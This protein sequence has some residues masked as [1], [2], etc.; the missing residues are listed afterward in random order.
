MLA[1]F[2]LFL[3]LAFTAV[4]PEAYGADAPPKVLG[5]PLSEVRS[6]GA[7]PADLATILGRGKVGIGGIADRNEECSCTDVLDPKFPM[8]RLVLGGSNSTRVVVAIERGGGRALRIEAVNYVRLNDDW[9]ETK[10]WNLSR[11]PV[12]LLDLL[13]L[14]GEVAQ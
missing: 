8:R 9:K 1:R 5:Q 2:T 3:G 12:T 13:D 10:R 4:A 11:R 6:L 7:L 14:I